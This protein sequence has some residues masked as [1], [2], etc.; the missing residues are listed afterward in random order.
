MTGS[1]KM[2]VE[3]TTV[4]NDVIRLEP[5]FGFKHPNHDHKNLYVIRLGVPLMQPAADPVNTAIY[6]MFRDHFKHQMVVF[7]RNYSEEVYGT[8]EL[9]IKFGRF[10]VLS[11]PRSFVED[12]THLTS[13][14]LVKAL[15]RRK[16]REMDPMF[17]GGRRQAR[18]SR[19]HVPQSEGTISTSFLSSVEMRKA[20][21]RFLKGLVDALSKFEYFRIL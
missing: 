18:N 13:E 17:D 15:D 16:T 12:S 7:N 11:P 5:Y 2:L 4:E 6:D 8:P 10:Y 21:T 20:E 14:E 3:G 9:Q 19:F 1:H